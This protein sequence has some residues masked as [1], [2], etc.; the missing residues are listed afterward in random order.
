[1]ATL[2]NTG[3]GGIQMRENNK[4]ESK[5]KGRSKKNKRKSKSNGE[6]KEGNNSFVCKAKELVSNL[7]TTEAYVAPFESC[8][9]VSK[10]R[11]QI[12]RLCHGR[13]NTICSD[14]W[15]VQIVSQELIDAL[16]AEKEKDDEAKE[17][18]EK[19]DPEVKFEMTRGCDYFIFLLAREVRVRVEA[20]GFNGPR[21][22][23]FPLAAFVSSVASDIPEFIPIME[24]YVY[25]AC[26]LALPVPLGNEASK[27]DF[28]DTLGMKK[29][30]DGEYESF[31]RFLQRTEGLIS[32]V[33][34]VMSSHPSDHTLFG[35]NEGAI[36]WL[37]RF[38]EQ[39]PKGPGQLPLFVAPVLHAFLAG[40]GHMLAIL[41]K[42]EFDKLVKFILDDVIGRLDE[43]PIGAPSAHRLKE[44]VENGL[45]GFE[46]IQ[47]SRALAPLYNNGKAAPPPPPPHLK[48]PSQNGLVQQPEPIYRAQSYS[49]AD[50]SES[51]GIYGTSPIPI[52]RAQSCV[53]G[54][55]PYIG[56][57]YGAQS[58]GAQPFGAQ[59]FSAQPFRAQSFGAQP[60]VARPFGAQPFG[61][62][63]CAQPFGVHSYSAQSYGGHS[64]G[65]Q[66]YNGQSY[67]G[68]YNTQLHNTQ[69]YNGNSYNGTSYN[70]HSYNSQM[71]N[72]QSY[73]AQPY[74][75]SSSPSPV[76]RERLGSAPSP[77]GRSR[78]II[79]T[80]WKKPASSL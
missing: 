31:E 73:N 42:E 80:S 78:R 59:P 12:K 69:V 7:I 71:Y 61:A 38:L 72:P 24:G 43:G 11:I 25:D 58:Y 35:G 15:K 14:V 47:P 54:S 1:M 53:Y 5:E 70:G 41:H 28:S 76:R 77:V 39:L 49:Y 75:L 20:E 66:A 4:D 65:A 9:A 21:G 6:R 26:P 57:S 37:D 2:G 8:E 51:D 3:R 40:A 29:D 44:C 17:R 68:E 52:S 18:S 10:R 34:N 60:F 74:G 36:Q 55:Q 27:D 45:E 16:K 48:F 62:Q 64:F 33:A 23:G 22:D 50:T 67:N 63:P 32:F 56:Q 79:A 30:R 13:V 46:G 19:R